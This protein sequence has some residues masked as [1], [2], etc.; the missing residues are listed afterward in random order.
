VQEAGEKILLLPAWPAD[1]DVDFRLHVAGG[2]VVQ[3]TVT[4]GRLRDWSIAPASRAKDV[5]VHH[6]QPVK[7]GS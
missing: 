6:P 2:T 1:W 4:G 3:G 7:P 5:V